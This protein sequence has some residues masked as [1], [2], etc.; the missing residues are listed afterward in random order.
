MDGLI[1][2]MAAFDGATVLTDYETVINSITA[3]LNTGGITTVLTY[4]AG[5]A[6]G[7]VFLW[8]AVRKAT[9]II[10]RAFMRGKLRL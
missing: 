4:A 2:V 5:I 9:S 3:E 1:P 10:K 6:V 7:M 8:W